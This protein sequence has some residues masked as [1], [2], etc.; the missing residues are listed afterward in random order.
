MTPLIKEIRQIAE[1]TAAYQMKEFRKFPTGY[2]SEKDQK[3]YV[4]EID[5][6]SEEIIKE[7]LS[8][9]LPEAG[10][11]G[12]ESGRTGSRET[13]WIVDPLDGTTNYLSGIDHFSVSI[14]LYTENSLKAGLVLKSST[15][16]AY[17]AEK[18][19]G[20]F[21]NDKKLKPIETMKPSSSL[22]CTGFPYRSPDLRQNFYQCC[23]QVLSFSRGLRR[24]GSAALDIAMLA[25]GYFQ[26][27]WESDL[28]A[29]DAAAALAILE[30]NGGKWS[31]TNHGEYT[32][33]ETRLFVAG[34]DET[35]TRLHDA[36]TECYS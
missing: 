7:G 9:L 30:E 32:L 5:V 28:Q 12:E 4:S 36:V 31:S 16:D 10:F 2:G 11:F 15:N 8:R 17:Y 6:N 35:F 22:I 21:H 27:F 3:E 23:D 20:A 34:W 14:A 13:Y 1:K 33:G 18:G 26:G 25:A 29:Y 19:H 24:T